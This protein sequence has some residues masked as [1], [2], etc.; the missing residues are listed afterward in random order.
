[1][2]DPDDNLL[3]LQARGGDEAL[4][5]PRKMPRTVSAEFTETVRRYHKALASYKEAKE[6]ALSQSRPWL[7]KVKLYSD[8]LAQEIASM[9]TR[10][11]CR[12]AVPVGS[13][14]YTI[15]PGKVSYA[16]ITEDFAAQKIMESIRVSGVAFSDQQL[17]VLE[18]GIK[19]IFN[20]DQRKVKKSNV[21]WELDI[22]E[23][24]SL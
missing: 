11:N 13:R 20:Q 18:N 24:L 4:P 3:L 1:V 21:K 10:Q 9:Q 16:P 2:D 15:K 7:N 8:A 19:N 12:I 14:K 22:E 6:K 23:S 5:K 17:R